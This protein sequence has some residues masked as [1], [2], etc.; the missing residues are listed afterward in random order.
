MSSRATIK[1]VGLALA[2]LLVA[3]GVAIAAS[4]LASQQ[5]GL[6]S[7]PISAGDA[8]APAAS[9]NHGHGSQGPGHGHGDRT[10]PTA[11]ATTPEPQPTVP[12]PTPEREA[13]TPTT[14]EGEPTTPTSPSNGAEDDHG[15]SGHGADD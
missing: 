12:T 2:G 4:N 5:I 7:E 1:W 8:L 9:P 3:G 10:T 14:P 11:P 15:S 13:A 6:A